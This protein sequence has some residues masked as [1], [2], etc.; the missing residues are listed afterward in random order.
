M[1]RKIT[2]LS[3]LWLASALSLSAEKLQETFTQDHPIDPQGSISLDNVNGSVRID[4][5]DEES[6]R[7]EGV[8]RARTQEHLDNLE[9]KID[10][11]R[12][13][14]T[15]KTNL[16]DK[17]LRKNP[18]SIDYVLTVPRNCKLD[19]IR[20]VNGPIEITGVQ[21]EVDASSV[22]GQVTATGLRNEADLSTVNGSVRAS[23]EEGAHPVS[24][25]SVNGS[26]TLRL[27]E[28]CH[29]SVEAKSV[30]GAIHCDFPV[31][32]GEGRIRKN[33]LK[34]TIGEGGPEVH[35]KTVNGAIHIE[36]NAS[37]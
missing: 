6:V 14:L 20:T 28:S 12:D 24:L 17:G 18:G 10:S 31:T 7:I 8:K 32:I 29:A 34:G 15:I 25:K 35:L 30:N 9:V 4:V 27:P 5:W 3:T 37:L 22:N 13:R 1:I 36:K 23:F 19:G 16:I 2:F 26:V 33:S 21:G 11:S